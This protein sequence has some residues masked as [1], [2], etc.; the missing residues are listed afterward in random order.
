MPGPARA[1]LAA[2]DRRDDDALTALGERALTGGDGGAGG[3]IDPGAAC[4]LNAAFEVAWTRAAALLDAE[5]IE[6]LHP[7]GRCPVCGSAPVASVVHAVSG[8]DGVRFLHCA[9]CSTEWHYVRVKCA[10][11]TSTKGIAYQQIEGA[12]GAVKAET[13]DECGTYTKI[14]Y[15][16]NDPRLEP[17]ADD[18]ASYGLDILVEEAGWR[19]A[20]ANPF[21]VPTAEAG[22]GAGQ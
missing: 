19:R 1:V 20:A 14:L 17:V 9:L 6:R 10:N 21:L 4:F 11:C 16:Q 7:P 13:C 12:G 5:R 8:L 15:L 2:L 3:G 18:L 22:D